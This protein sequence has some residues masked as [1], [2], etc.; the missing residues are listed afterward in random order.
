MQL[1]PQ[2][3]KEQKKLNR[4]LLLT[5]MFIQEIDEDGLELKETTLNLKNKLEE[6]N[7]ILLPIL[8]KFYQNKKVRKTLFYSDVMKSFDYTFN[9]HFHIH[10]KVK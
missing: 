3:I 2:E 5:D 1:I 4:L 10:F 7:E 6:V 8:D 9:R